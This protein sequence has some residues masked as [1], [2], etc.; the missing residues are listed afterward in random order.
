MNFR[1]YISPYLCIRSDRC[2]NGGNCTAP[3]VCT[4]P[5]GWSGYDCKTPTCEVCTYVRSLLFSSLLF[6]YFI[7]FLTLLSF[8][9]LSLLSFLPFLS[10][11]YFLSSLSFPFLSFPFLSF[12]LMH[13]FFRS[14]LLFKVV[15]DTLTREQLGTVYE[16]KGETH[17]R[18]LTAV[19]LTHNQT[20]TYSRIHMYSHYKIECDS[21]HFFLPFPPLISVFFVTLYFLF[22]V[23]LRIAILQ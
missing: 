2:S 18:I 3:D 13:A 22:I 4:C 21:Q 23:N 15:A 20:L 11:P 6:S 10:F 16:D 8:P 1:I 12:P 9:F 14:F 7:P 17:A 19:T 5:S